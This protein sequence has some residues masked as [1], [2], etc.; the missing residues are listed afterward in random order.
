MGVSGHQRTAAP[1]ALGT[2][3]QTASKIKA[4]V[5]GPAMKPTTIAAR[6]DKAHIAAS[7]PPDGMK[8]SRTRKTRPS[9][10]RM[11]AQVTGFIGEMSNVESQMTK[12]SRMT[13][14][15]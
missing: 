13:K 5:P 3:T 8:N 6:N 1:A 9:S 4:P 7:A 11:M 2:M 15:D 14:H 12:E 10:N